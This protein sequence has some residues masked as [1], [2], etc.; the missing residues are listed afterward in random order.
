MASAWLREHLDCG[1]WS[2]AS[3]TVSLHTMPQRTGREVT[4]VVPAV[5]KQL[6]WYAATDDKDFTV[7]ML[8]MLFNKYRTQ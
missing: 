4:Y 2:D 6:H 1:I 5:L 3:P 8:N 7:Y